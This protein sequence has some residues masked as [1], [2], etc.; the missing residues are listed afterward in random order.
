[1]GRAL[2]ELLAERGWAVAVLGRD[3]AAARDCAADIAAASRAEVIGDG[4]LGAELGP[5]VARVADRLGGLDGLAVSAGPIAS[6]GRFPELDDAAWAEMFDTQVMTAVRAIRAAIPFLARSPS[7]SIV[8][9][10]A[11]SIRLHKAILPHYAAMKSAI[12]ALTKHLALYQ[13]A[14]GIRANCIAP[15]AIA[16]E[17]LSSARE[18]GARDFGG[19]PLDA[20]WQVMKRDWG[21]TSALDRIGQPHEVAALAAFLLSPESGY[22]SGA[23]I[24]IDGGSYF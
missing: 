8:T 4:G 6:R 3:A 10:A 13:G 22:I 21:T 1:M 20:L 24:N 19:E 16:T 11:Q 2:A 12:A 5:A 18:A 14:D 17:A 15:G 23:T 9:F 7:G